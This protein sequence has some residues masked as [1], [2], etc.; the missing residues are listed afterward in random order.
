M[1]FPQITTAGL[2]VVLER[3]V[4]RFNLFIIFILNNLQSS[5]ETEKEGDRSC[6]FR[7]SWVR[8]GCVR[9]IAIIDGALFA[10]FDG[11]GWGPGVVNA[12]EHRAGVER[13]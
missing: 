3:L 11:R 13:S 12:V 2:P 9:V 10:V 6:D 5:Y 8:G 7:A 4:K 1:P